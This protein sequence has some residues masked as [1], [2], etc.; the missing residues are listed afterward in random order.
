[1]QRGKLERHMARLRNAIQLLSL[2]QQ[3]YTRALLRVQPDLIAEKILV[4][5]KKNTAKFKPNA[6]Q[7]ESNIKSEATK[8]SNGTTEGSSQGE[9][10]RHAHISKT[11]WR[12]SLPSWLSSRAL[13]IY[14][15]KLHHGWQWVFR[16]YNVIPST[17]KVVS[18]TV[19]GKIDDLQDLFSMK[20][21][22]P[23][24]RTDRFGYTLLHYAMLGPRKE[25]V[26]K[27]LLDQGVDSSIAGAHPNLETPLHM[28]VFCGT[29]GLGK[30][31]LLFP[32]LR[33]LLRYAKESTYEDTPEETINGVLSRFRGSSEE[34]KFLQRHYCPS[35][36]EMPQ[37]I[38][39]AVASKAAFGVWDA[40]H[41][42]DLIQ[43]MLGPDPLTAK[44]LQLEGPWRF[45]SKNTTLVHCVVRK[46]GATQAALQGSH[47]W[48][49]QVR[50]QSRSRGPSLYNNMREG[51]Y[52][53]YKSWNKLFMGFL[54]AGVDLNN[55]VD[56]QTLLLAFLEGYTD[57]LDIS[58]CQMSS[59]SEAL[60]KWL[61]DLKSA[62]VDLQKFGEIEDSMWK[63]ELIRRDIGPWD[64]ENSGCHR[65]IGFS[66]G[67]RIDD[68]SVWLSP[69][70]DNFIGDFWS[71]IERPAETM[72]GGWPGELISLSQF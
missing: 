54:Q 43:T 17:S 49:K 66:Y 25:E 11:L 48:K 28:L 40:Y 41:M 65:L 71:L 45:D 70:W 5:G 13:E 60:R 15:Q 12:L 35:Y 62:G 10:S 2:S 18:L 50:H 3:C 21:A 64:G 39:I 4:Q 14:S 22:S 56:Q 57:W 9:I 27:F 51:Y 34:F 8:L 32:C 58:K 20:Q 1:M 72:A 6:H 69:K 24:D 23:F 44:E 68:W 46:I 52:D 59:P 63:M 16:T 30:G 42:P 31:Q 61:T 29:L 53:L 33:L 55:I 36:Y 26:L 47:P 67:P 7:H 37:E 38:R 19:A